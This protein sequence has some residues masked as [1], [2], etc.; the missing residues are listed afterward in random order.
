MIDAGFLKTGL[1][2]REAIASDE[3]ERETVKASVV[4]LR[5]LLYARALI[6]HRYFGAVDQGPTW[7]GDYSRNR[8][9]GDGI[10]SFRKLWQAGQ[11]QDGG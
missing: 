1:L 10:L 7:V 6:R 4:C 9:T 5:G 8:P 3:D 11:N 2:K